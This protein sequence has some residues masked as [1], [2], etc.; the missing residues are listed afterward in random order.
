MCSRCFPVFARKLVNLPPM[1]YDPCFIGQDFIDL[2]E[3]KIQRRRVRF[4]TMTL[5]VNRSVD[6]EKTH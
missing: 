1:M 5:P 4:H 6:K 2:N 3:Y